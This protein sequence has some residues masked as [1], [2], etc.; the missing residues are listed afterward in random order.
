MIEA[1]QEAGQN[2]QPSRRWRFLLLASLALNL[3]FA[4]MA[5]GLMWNWKRHHDGA[6]GRAGALSDVALQGFLK[7]LPKAR[8]KDLRQAIK[9]EGRPDVRGLTNAV[10][11]ARRQ[12]AQSLAAEPFD[13]AKLTEAFS[14]I[15]AAEAANK[16]AIRK[17]LIT[18]A[19]RMTAA[20]RQAL[21]SHWKARKPRMF[22]DLPAKDDTKSSTDDDAAP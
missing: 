9:Q 3:A 20:E 7:T 13:S 1:P 18:A 4:G 17:T 10:R 19:G 15:D 22:E 21:A 14:G 16:A 6:G 12:A 8:A 5:A 2:V 11:Q